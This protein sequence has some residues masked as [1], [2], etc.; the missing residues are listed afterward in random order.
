[1]TPACKTHMKDLIEA[2]TSIVHCIAIIRFHRSCVGEL[3]ERKKV[4]CNNCNNRAIVYPEVR[5]GEMK[6]QISK[7]FLQK[8]S[9]INDVTRA[10]TALRLLDFPFSLQYARRLRVVH[11]Y[12]SSV[13]GTYCVLISM[14][15]N[16]CLS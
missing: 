6:S 9:L 7:C 16:Q 15:L 5:R 14:K 11:T 2:K 8:W 12:C 1:M 3:R 10:S 4:Y 13:L